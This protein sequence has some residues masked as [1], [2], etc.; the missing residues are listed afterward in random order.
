MQ[1]IF[2]DFGS[3]KSM[4]MVQ[5]VYTRHR[6]HFAQQLCSLEVL[7]SHKLEPLNSCGGALLSKSPQAYR[8]D[9]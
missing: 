7:S 3:D 2:G 4:R 6:T 1:S 9:G 5:K 8:N